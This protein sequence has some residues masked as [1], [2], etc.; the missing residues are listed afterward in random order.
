MN[1]SNLSIMLADDDNDDCFFFNEAL[2]E[3]AISVKLL[4][5][6]NGDDLLQTLHNVPA[7]PDIIFIDM[8]M[9]K[10]NGIESLTEIKNSERLSHIPVVIYSTSYQP[11]VISQLYA[12]GASRFICKPPE[13]SIFKDSLHKAILFLVDSGGKQAPF[14]KFILPN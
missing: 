5:V 10:K 3:L 14:E 9:P 13:F 6:N 2:N 12:K 4:I 1:L 7:L 11:E 8:N